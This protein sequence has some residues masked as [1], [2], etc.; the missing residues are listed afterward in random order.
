M[1]KRE[2]GRAWVQ[3]E[4]DAFLDGPIGD[5]SCH[6]EMAE[7]ALVTEIAELADRLEILG[8]EESDGVLSWHLWLPVERGTIEAFGEYEDFVEAGEVSNHDEFVALWREH[9]PTDIAIDRRPFR[10]TIDRERIVIV[11]AERLVITVDRENSTIG[12]FRFVSDEVRAFLQWML[13]EAEAEVERLAA[14]PRGH[15]RYVESEVLPRRRFGKLS[16]RDL[17][18]VVPAAT[19]FDKELGDDVLRGFEALFPQTDRPRLTG[20]MTLK[21]FL[22]MCEIAYDANGYD[23]LRP[24]MTAREKYDR[25][26]DG[27]HEGLLDVSPADDPR[28]FR[29]WFRERPRGG[30][31]WE[32]CRGGNATHISLQV[33]EEDGGWTIWL[34]GLSAARCVETV[35]M[36]VS[37][38]EQGIPV[39]VVQGEDLLRM[40]RGEDNLGIVPDGVSPRYASSLFP[41]EDRVLQCVEFWSL[42]PYAE[43]LL[44]CIEWYPVKSSVPCSR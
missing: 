37:L 30:H 28:A 27:R 20:T 4:V 1:D 22:Q 17:W 18:M 14:D 33:V 43:A 11:F 21:R 35:K 5:T 10:L 24:N 26:A 25:M 19:R 16:R 41:D 39:H 32:I 40:V 2:Q 7:P 42:E 9:Y 6:A 13:D 15:G 31:P 38:H 29:R 36:A 44:P 8:P 34:A 23:H 12:G 3:P